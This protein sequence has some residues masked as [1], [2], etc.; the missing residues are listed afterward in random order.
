VSLSAN[1]LNTRLNAKCSWEERERRVCSLQIIALGSIVIIISLGLCASAIS[2]N[3]KAKK[4]ECAPQS[5]L[6]L[7]RKYFAAGGL[8]PPSH[9]T[10]CTIGWVG[11]EARWVVRRGTLLQW[12]CRKSICFWVL[13]GNGKCSQLCWW[14]AKGSHLFYRFT[15][16]ILILQ[17]II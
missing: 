15:L 9:Y 13:L 5:I 11:R 3:A 16:M 17:N 10:P 7:G 14:F 4:L 8:L 6:S 1:T 12:Q 2:P